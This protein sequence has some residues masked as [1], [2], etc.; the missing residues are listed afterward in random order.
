[1]NVSKLM[2]ES[3][4]PIS[5]STSLV[6]AAAAMREHDTGFLPV[7][8]DGRLVGIVTDRDLVVR[9][10]AENRSPVK[11]QV[12]EL[13]SVEVVCC[14]ADQ[15]QED[16][17]ALVSDH[18]VRWL[19]VIDHEHRLLGVLTRHSLGLSEQSDSGKKPVKVTFQKTKTDSYGHMHKIPLKTVYVT[20][21]KS[22]AEA[23]ETARHHYE[24]EQGTT[25]TNV[26]DDMSVQ[27]EREDSPTDSSN[28]KHD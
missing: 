28:P 11:T 18:D 26:A 19:P 10:L 24:E 1:M 14:F 17:R 12:H 6:E 5:R 27:N 25:W 13:M 22:K 16:A 15:S 8:E 4:S 2:M 20:N 21:V 23:I 9:G 7:V 3:A